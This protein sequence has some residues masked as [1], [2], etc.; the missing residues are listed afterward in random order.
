MQSYPRASDLVWL[1][2]LHG[3]GCLSAP[4]MDTG[5]LIVVWRLC[6]HPGC[7]WV[8]VSVTPPA[9][10]GVFAGCFWVRVVVS[11]LH[12][13]LGFVVFAVGLGF[14]PAPHHSWLGCWGVCAF[15][16]APRLYPA[17]PGWGVRC[18]RMCWARVSAVSRLPWLGC[19]GVCVFVRVPRLHPAIPGGVGRV[20]LGLGFVCSAVFSWLGCWGAWPLVCVLSV[21]RH[22]LGEACGVG[23][24][25]CCLRWG[26]F[27]PLPFGILLQGGLSCR[28]VSLL[29]GVCCWL[30]RD[31]VLWSQSPPPLMFRLRLRVFFFCPSQEVLQLSLRLLRSLHRGPR[32]SVLKYER[33]IMCTLL[34]N[35]KW[36]QQLPGP[37]HSEEFGEGML[38]KLVL[39][40]AKNTGSV[41]VDEVENHY[42]VLNVGPGGKR[43]GVQDVPQNLVYRMRQRLRRFSAT[44]RIRMAYVEWESHRVSTVA[45]SWPRRLPSFPSSPTQPLGYDH[46]RLLGHSVL[47]CLIDQKTNPTNQ[48]KQKLDASVARRTDMDGDRQ[49][50]ATRNVR[51]HMR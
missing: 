2:H 41:T 42:L 48:L 4:A 3:T 12:S 10:A 17:I 15:V 49:E 40:K 36:H 50:A 31:W 29:C 6:L 5:F 1:G 30:F 22:L 7:A 35:S 26:L 25:G 16:C 51:H 45:T 47:D 13:P 24:C 38:S 43:V 44:D 23:V 21:S 34:Y 32:D 9:L 8:R 33:T 27:P 11:P 14:W 20:C 37:A 46:Y 39:E 19:W 18:G 28:S